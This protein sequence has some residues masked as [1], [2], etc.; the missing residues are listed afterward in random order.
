MDTTRGKAEMPS[1]KRIVSAAERSATTRAMKSAASL[2]EGR[3][4]RLFKQ[5][6]WKSP[7]R[8]IRN[9]APPH[10][11]MRHIV[12]MAGALL[13]GVALRQPFAGLVE[14]LSGEGGCLRRIALPAIAACLSGEHR[15][16][17]VPHLRGD[18]RRMKTLVH[19][20]LVPD[21]PDLDRV[22]QHL[23]DV[24]AREPAATNGLAIA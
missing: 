6:R 22:A 5:G 17:L 8:K 4:D 24:P 19:E 23:V 11:L 10:Q 12:S 14:Q 13:V 21:A 16:D 1:R 3:G 15:L 18:D 2:T 7:A 20:G 9:A